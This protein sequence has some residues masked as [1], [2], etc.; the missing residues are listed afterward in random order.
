MIV[1]VTV[2][3]GSFPWPECQSLISCCLDLGLA[4]LLIQ[5]RVMTQRQHVL[6]TESPLY[7]TILIFD[8][9]NQ[10]QPTTTRLGE[11]FQL[12][13]SLFL[14][15]LIS[16]STD[17]FLLGSAAYSIPVYSDH[18]HRTILGI[19][20]VGERGRRGAGGRAGNYQVRKKKSE[21][22]TVPQ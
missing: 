15:E 1:F 8:F 12:W 9:N 14:G 18:H 10:F 4:T 16:T 3:W 19:R 5:L 13:G 17:F 6:A 20:C 21:T 22:E 7:H 11:I 2:F